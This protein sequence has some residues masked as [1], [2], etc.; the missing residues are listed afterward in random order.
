MTVLKLFSPP[1]V[2]GPREDQIYSFF[3]ACSKGICP[4]IGDGNKPE[5]S[6][7]YVSDLVDGILTGS[8]KKETGIHTYFISGEGTHSWNEIRGSDLKSVG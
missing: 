2:Y 7:V 8:T 3:K 5:V 1:A 4:I 6:M